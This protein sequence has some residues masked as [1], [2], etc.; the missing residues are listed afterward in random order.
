MSTPPARPGRSCGSTSANSAASSNSASNPRAAAQSRR[1]RAAASSSGSAATQTVPHCKYSASAGNS[2]ASSCHNCRD[3]A[4]SR[5]WGSE[6]CMTT[7]WPMPAAVAPAPGKAGSATATRSP[8][9]VSSRAQAA[10]TMPAPAM[11]T[12]KLELIRGTAG[13]RKHRD[14]AG[15]MP[16]RRCRMTVTSRADPPAEGVAFVQNQAPFGGYESRAADKRPQLAV[17]LLDVAL[18]KAADDALLPV[19]LAGLEQPIGPQ[20][21]H[22]GAGARAAGRTVVGLAGAQHE[23]AAGRIGRGLGEQLDVVDLAAAGAMDALL[24]QGPADGP[25]VTRELLQMV[26]IQRITVVVGEE[27]PV[28][29][30]GHVAVHVA[31]T[32]HVNNGVAQQSVRGHVAESHFAVFVEF[33]GDNADRRLDAMDAGTDAAHP[34]QRDHQADGPMAAHAQ[35]A[36]VVEEDDAGG[37]GGVDGHAQQGAD[38]RVGAA[39][40]IDHGRAKQ[41]V[42]RAE[43]LEAFGEWSDAEV[44]AS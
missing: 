36:D 41:V 21:G 4:V 16:L 1:R 24:A 42:L 2:G 37:A 19:G 5:N 25:G 20:A 10:P 40:F 27:E 44:R 15:R 28:A 33:R 7:R 32:G 35:I 31:M 17:T 23:V 22:F 12:S 34:G 8:E 6:S 11:T 26:Q 3:Q 13:R 43:A 29:A 18:E 39:R 14:S 38:D 9:R 30:P